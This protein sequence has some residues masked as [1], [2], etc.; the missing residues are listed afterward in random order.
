MIEGEKAETEA[1]EGPHMMDL[2]DK[3]FRA[4]VINMCKLCCCEAAGGS[5]GRRAQG[6]YK[7][8]E[9]GQGAT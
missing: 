7:R 6:S 1:F 9:G 8:L 3:V 4:A 5:G 2:A